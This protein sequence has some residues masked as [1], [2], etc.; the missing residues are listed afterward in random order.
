MHLRAFYTD[1][2]DDGGPTLGPSFTKTFVIPFSTPDQA[3]II[4]QVDPVVTTPNPTISVFLPA[5][6]PTLEYELAVYRVQDNP[7]DAVQNGTPLWRERITDGRTIIVYPS[8]ATPLTSGNRYVIAGVSYFQTSASQQ[9]RRIDA[10]LV[11]FRYDDPST[12]SSSSNTGGSNTPGQDATRPDPLVTIFG[13]TATQIPPA[14]AQQ[15]TQ[16]IR[17]LEDRGWTLSQFR[18]NN[19]TIT[20]VELMNIL[21]QFTNATISVVE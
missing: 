11:Q 20:Q 18:Y 7:R 15:L 6:R 8:T 17:R 4:V 2:I 3:K 10:D 12:S 14:I 5:E 9:K 21:S 16:T 1:R 19:R 13:S